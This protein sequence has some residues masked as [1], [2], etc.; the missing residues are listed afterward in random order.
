MNCVF[1]GNAAIAGSGGAVFSESDGAIV[2]C[3]FV[4]NSAHGSGDAIRNT[5]LGMRFTNCIFRGSTT[6]VDSDPTTVSYSN[7]EGI[8]ADPLLVD[9][10]NGDY[11]LQAGSPCIDAGHNW[12]VPRD[13]TDLDA[14]GDTTE[15]TP[16]DLNGGPRFADRVATVDTGCGATALVDMGAYEFQ[17]TAL[18]CLQPGDVNEDGQVNV[19]DLIALLLVFGTSCEDACCPADFDFSG[20]VNVLDLIELL[21]RFGTACP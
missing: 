9:P 17:G 16:L 2:N 8:D 14:D 3:T 10:G 1:S 13:S 11:R 6:Q 19:L 12:A 18:A 20:S 4:D 7:I 5:N 15:L 21:L